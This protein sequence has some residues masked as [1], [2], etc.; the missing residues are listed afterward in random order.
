MRYQ[1]VDAPTTAP[2]PYLNRQGNVVQQVDASTLDRFEGV[3]PEYRLATAW[4]MMVGNVGQKS[5]TVKIKIEAPEDPGD[6]R[7]FIGILS[8]DFLGADQEVSVDVKVLPAS[9]GGEATDK[10]SEESKKEK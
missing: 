3:D 9:K 1:R 5:G 6:Y 7:F 2:K 10:A 8:Q 4:P